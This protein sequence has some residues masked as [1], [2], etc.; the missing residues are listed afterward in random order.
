MAFVVVKNWP[1]ADARALEAEA[2]IMLAPYRL[3]DRRE[4]FRAPLQTLDEVLRALFTVRRSRTQRYRAEALSHLTTGRAC[5]HCGRVGSDRP[6]DAS[7]A[8]NRIKQ[9]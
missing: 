7:I 1:H 6:R 3:N 5:S 9:L 4:F 2:H 8:A